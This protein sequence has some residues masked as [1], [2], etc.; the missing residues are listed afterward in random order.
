MKDWL[1]RAYESEVRGHRTD[2]LAY[3][4]RAAEKAHH[5]LEPVEAPEEP[6]NVDTLKQLS[7]A[8]EDLAFLVNDCSDTPPHRGAA[9]SAWSDVVRRARQLRS[10]MAEL[11]EALTSQRDMDARPSRELGYGHLQHERL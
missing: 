5:T 3:I 4:K 1:I 2:S 6:V 8:I 11:E 10:A 7:S 9:V